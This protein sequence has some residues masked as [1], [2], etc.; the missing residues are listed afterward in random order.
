MQ[1]SKYF[2]PETLMF[3][4]FLAAL[5]IYAPNQLL[6]ETELLQQAAYMPAFADT[7]L[8]TSVVLGI[9]AAI[10]SARGRLPMILHRWVVLGSS[11]AYVAGY[12]LFALAAGLEGFAQPALGVLAGLLLGVSTVVLAIAWGAH[13]AQFDLRQALLWLSLIHI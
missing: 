2:K 1:I 7:L 5:P 10:A 9:A 13:L 12:G 4:A 11:A 8:V 6:F 3:A